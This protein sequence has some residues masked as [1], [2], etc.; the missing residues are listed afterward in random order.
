[1]MK[2]RMITPTTIRAISPASRPP[3]E[4]GVVVVLGAGPDVVAVVDVVVEAVV[5]V[6]V[7]VGVVVGGG[8]NFKT[9]P[10]VPTA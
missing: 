4:A 3:V 5:V 1:M 8:P 7:V 9:V 10:P 6:V 2:T